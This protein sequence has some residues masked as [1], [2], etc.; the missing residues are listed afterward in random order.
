MIWLIWTLFVFWAGYL[1]GEY[2]FKQRTFPHRFSCP[3]CKEA[4]T[5]FKLAGSDKAILRNIM[6]EHIE[7][8]HPE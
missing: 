4:G 6:H 1:T 7:S 3:N 8:R 5:P 2:V